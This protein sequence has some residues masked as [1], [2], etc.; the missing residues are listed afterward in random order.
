MSM[1][2]IGS[3]A[4]YSLYKIQHLPMSEQKIGLSNIFQN[5]LGVKNKQTDDILIIGLKP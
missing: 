3:D 5:W 1:S 4:K 2:E